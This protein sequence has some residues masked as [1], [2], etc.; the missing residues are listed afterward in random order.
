MSQHKVFRKM[1]AI[2]I[3]FKA[4]ACQD[5]KART[6]KPKQKS[7]NG[8]ARTVKPKQKSQNSKA[9]TVKLGQ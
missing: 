7:Q 2:A 4:L 6:V 3:H 8:K 5:S 1:F 9:R